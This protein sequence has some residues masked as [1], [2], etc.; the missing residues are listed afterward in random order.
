VE[1]LSPAGVYPGVVLG[2]QGE[3]SPALCGHGGAVRRL[4]ADGAREGV[5]SRRSS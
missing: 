4:R 2:G 3:P 5:P 1:A